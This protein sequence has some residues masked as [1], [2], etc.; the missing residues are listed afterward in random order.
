MRR[1][2]D[3]VVEQERFEL[4]DLVVQSESGGSVGHVG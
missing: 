2:T 4:I 1:Y 3:L